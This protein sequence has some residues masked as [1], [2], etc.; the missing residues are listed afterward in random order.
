MQSFGKFLGIS[1]SCLLIEAFVNSFFNIFVIYLRFLVAFNRFLIKTAIK[2]Q[3][4]DQKSHIAV[5]L[6]LPG[7]TANIRRQLSKKTKPFSKVK[8]CEED[9]LKNQVHYS[10][11]FYKN[12]NEF[13]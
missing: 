10:F 4:F 9:D 12:H 11:Y 5:T 13:M 1:L 3:H 2:E 7:S 8:S 6:L